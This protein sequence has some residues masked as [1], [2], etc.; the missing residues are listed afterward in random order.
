[1]TTFM[2]NAWHYLVGLA[3]IGSISGLIATGSVTSKA[4]VPIITAIVAA[5]IG[6]G[7][8]KAA[9]PTTTIAV[10]PTKPTTTTTTGSVP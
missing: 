6:A 9:G 3:G 4:G 8:T 1:M 2:K 7:A 5:L 10:T